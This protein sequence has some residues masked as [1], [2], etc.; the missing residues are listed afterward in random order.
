LFTRNKGIISIITIINSSWKRRRR[1]SGSGK[2]EGEEGPVPD[3]F[4][5]LE[6]EVSEGFPLDLPEVFGREVEAA[7]FQHRAVRKGSV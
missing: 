2:R 6:L 1:S 7:V 3:A 5:D 4:F